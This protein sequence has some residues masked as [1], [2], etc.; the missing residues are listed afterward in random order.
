MWAPKGGASNPEK[1]R[2]ARWGPNGGAPKGGDDKQFSFFLPLVGVFSLNFGCVEA[3]SLKCARLD[4]SGC[5]VKPRRPRRPALP[6]KVSLSVAGVDISGEERGP[7]TDIFLEG[8][9][10][11]VG[12]KTQTKTRTS[13]CLLRSRS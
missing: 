2:P 7:Q 8:G 5:C 1:R 11:E 4:F 13:L 12:F 3:G 6:K 9:G 10:G